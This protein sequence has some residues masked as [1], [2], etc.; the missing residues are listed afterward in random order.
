MSAS[1]RDTTIS[2]AYVGRV[3]LH[4]E[5]ERDLNAL[6]PA[7]ARRI[8]ALL[9]MPCDPTRVSRF[10]PMNENA[11]RSEYNGLQSS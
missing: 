10:I 8:R 6:R 7:R 5:R 3:G 1:F 2:L 9:S 11:A 4:M